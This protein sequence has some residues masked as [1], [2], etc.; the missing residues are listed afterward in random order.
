MEFLKELE[1]TEDTKAIGM[2]LPFDEDT[3]FRMFKGIKINDNLWL[4]IQA[5]YGHYCT[6]RKTLKN[7]ED[8]TNM[9]FALMN[10]EREFVSL[11]DI[12]PTFSKL[13]EINECFEGSVYCY[14]PVDLIDELFK[15]LK[16]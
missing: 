1:V 4:S 5:S 7:I 3:T 12:L 6:P 8:Y 2:V 11:T 14:V 15:E 16:A 13:D 9:E 10:G